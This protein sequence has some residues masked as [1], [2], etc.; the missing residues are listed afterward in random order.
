[1]HH[2]KLKT[3]SLCGKRLKKVM[4][5]IYLP[6]KILC[7]ESPFCRGFKG[8]YLKKGTPSMRSPILGGDTS[9]SGTV[10]R[11]PI[12]NKRRKMSDR[13]IEAKTL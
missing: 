2:P 11:R 12:E 1:M 3:P 7:E 9:Y 10:P 8:K 6:L 5:F 13:Q 4:C